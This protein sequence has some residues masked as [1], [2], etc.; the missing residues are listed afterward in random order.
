[1]QQ[2]IF[3]SLLYLTCDSYVSIMSQ[4]LHIYISTSTEKTLIINL[5]K[6]QQVFL[7]KNIY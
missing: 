6:E 2:L 7:R 3:A 5:Y 4:H 1:M